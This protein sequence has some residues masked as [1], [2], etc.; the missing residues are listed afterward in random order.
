MRPIGRGS[1]Q[2]RRGVQTL[3]LILVTPVIVLALLATLEFGML[4]MTHAAITHATTVGARE[5]GKLD[6][7]G[8]IV[9]SEVVDEVNEVLGAIDIEIDNSRTGSRL[10][11]VDGDNPGSPLYEGDSSLTCT[12]PSPQAGEVSITLCIEFDATKLNG[13]PVINAFSY[14]GFT[15]NGKRFEVSALVKKEV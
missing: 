8:D 10:A 15:F 11:I 13:A 12:L 1:K 7:N 9:L 2:R 14:C 5:S 4:N 6:A 3:E